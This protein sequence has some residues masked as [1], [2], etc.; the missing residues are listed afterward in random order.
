MVFIRI[1]KKISNWA[2]NLVLKTL[3]VIDRE[4]LS[5]I[6]IEQFAQKKTICKK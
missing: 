1:K 2:V 6:D 4:V 5:P 3:V